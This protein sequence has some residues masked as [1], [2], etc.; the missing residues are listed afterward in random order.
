[1]ATEQSMSTSFKEPTE[2]ERIYANR[3]GEGELE[4]RRIFWKTLIEGFFQRMIPHNAAVLDLGCGYG[5][6]IN[7]ADCGTRLAMD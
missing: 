6:F 4:N 5:E 2:L 7:Q 1:M 3:F